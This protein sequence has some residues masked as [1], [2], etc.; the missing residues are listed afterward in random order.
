MSQNARRCVCTCGQPSVKTVSVMGRGCCIVV[1]YWLAAAGKV[2]RTGNGKRASKPINNTKTAP[3][4]I[5][6][7][8]YDLMAGNQC[9]AQHEPHQCL[10]RLDSTRF[11]LASVAAAESSDSHSLLHYAL[12]CCIEVILV[13]VIVTPRYLNRL[14][15]G[16]VPNHG[17]LRTKP[18]LRNWTRA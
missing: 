1:R 5:I 18:T 10:P 11:T 3:I 13:L 17:F 4:D 16:Y 15:S 9:G 14:W 7:R 8:S 2:S 6:A 12:R